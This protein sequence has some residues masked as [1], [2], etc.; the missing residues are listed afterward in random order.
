MAKRMTASDA[1]A[2]ALTL[3]VQTVLDI[4]PGP[5]DHARAFRDAG[6]AVWCMSPNPV[7]GFD[8]T[9]IRGFWPVEKPPEGQTF[10]LVWSSHCLEHALSPQLWLSPL[11]EIVHEQSWLAITVPP[12]K[13]D[14]VSGHVTLWNAGLLLVHLILAG[15]DCSDAAVKTYGY[16]CSVV[17]PARR[18]P[19]DYLPRNEHADCMIEDLAPYLPSGLELTDYGSF[20]GMIQSL[21][22]DS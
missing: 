22:W 7:P 13:D 10:D 15:F 1:L 18:L 9:T 20:D 2:K 8:S 16:N 4:G 17:T 21:N 19:V 11:H 3:P 12:H 14:I 6:K 5:G